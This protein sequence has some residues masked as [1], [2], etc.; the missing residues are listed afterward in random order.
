M[1]SGSPRK[2]AG[3]YGALDVLRSRGNSALIRDL[4]LLR[5]VVPELP[6]KDASEADVEALRNGSSFIVS[7]YLRGTFGP[8]PKRLTYGSLLVSPDRASWKPYIGLP[9]RR[10]LVIESCFV[11]VQTRPPGTREVLKVRNIERLRDGVMTPQW[12]VVSARGAVG[13]LDFVV[14]TP[15]VPL[16]SAWLYGIPDSSGPRQGS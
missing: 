3:T 15:D 8:Y 9:R 16:V 2:A 13:S 6:G 4:L 5:H 11:V 7:C 14:P 1:A 10:A 12:T